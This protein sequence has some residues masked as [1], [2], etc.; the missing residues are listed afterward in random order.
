MNYEFRIM[1]EFSKTASLLFTLKPIAKRTA[2]H[3]S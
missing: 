1:N 2:I 3:N